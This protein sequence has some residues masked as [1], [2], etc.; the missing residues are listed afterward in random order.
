MIGFSFTFPI[1]VLL[2]FTVAEI[3]KNIDFAR[4]ELS[5]TAY[6]RPLA[7]ILK[8]MPEHLLLAHRILAGDRS[9]ESQRTAKQGEIDDDFR[10]LEAVDRKLGSTLRLN[11]EGQDNPSRGHATT[12]SLA[13]EWEDLKRS[14]PSLSPEACDERHLHIGE[15]LRS[16]ITRVVDNSNLILDP[17]LDSYYLMNAATVTLPQAQYRLAKA[18]SEG[19]AALERKQLTLKQRVDL[20]TYAGM[21]R[22]ADL[23]TA[24]SSVQTA[25]REDNGFYGTSEL[26]QT[27]VPPAL[28]SFVTEFTAFIEALKKVADAEAAELT[29]DQLLALGMRTREA[30]YTFRSL[31]T[32]ELDRLLQARVLSFEGFRTRVLTIALLALAFATLLVFLVARSI[33]VPLA[34]CVQS[35][36]ALAARDLTGH[37]E[38]LGRD[39]LGQMSAA[40][41]Q[42]MQNLREG[43][44]SLGRDA[45]LLTRASEGLVTTSQQMCAN[46]EET[47]TQAN[48]V[49]AAAEQVSKSVQTVALATQEMSSSI[50]EVAKQTTEAARVATTGVRVAEAT[51]LTVAKLGESSSQ[52]GKVIKVI[53]SIAEQTNLLALNAT[54]EAARVGEA[55]R[56]F[57]VVANEVKE[58]ARETARATEEISQKIEAIQH[59][60]QGVVA[61]I[62][63]I[64]TI[65]NQINDIQNTIASAVEQQTV[66]TR[67]IGRNVAE[68]AGGTAEIARNI[69][70][71]A[72][73]ARNTS[74][75]AHVTEQAAGDLSRMAV[76][77]KELVGRFKCDST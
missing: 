25:L 26:L 72:E 8:R 12:Q 24:V 61:A 11:D 68:A 40:V 44:V 30:T 46:A 62:T 6:L 36:K 23:D 33:T 50:R 76:D 60:S 52:I 16:L 63:E 28:Q 3:N 49:S 57:A 55:G 1:A 77:L 67:E 71:V 22:E 20:S 74:E 19:Y 17:D 2:Y 59:D 65:I 14:L 38:V 75:G 51:N 53:T 45:T 39:E 58:L 7:R 35:L 27:N 56:G 66:T 54:I 41:A 37:V 18:I 47:S 69:M 10:A 31:L 73:A 64:G 9:L 15:G 32:D 4:Q 21:L 13:R 42:A 43:V 34:G 48:V 5:G 29:S 70:G